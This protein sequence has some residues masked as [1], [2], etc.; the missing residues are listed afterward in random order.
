M[1]EAFNKRKVFITVTILV[2][3]AMIVGMAF[4]TKATT[5]NPY[6]LEIM[7]EGENAKVTNSQIELGQKIIADESDDTK[8]VYEL[9][10]KN[11]LE[12]KANIEIAV[13]IDS[14]YSMRENVS[15]EE[16]TTKIGDLTT[17]ILTQVVNARISVSDNSGIKLALS[18]NANN[19]KSA[20]SSVV[21][22]K[23][24]KLETGVQYANS[25]FSTA[26]N[27]RKIYDSNNRCYR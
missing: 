5:A 23:G 4:F 10:M 27:T 22:G 16:L 6:V 9:N 25:S 14:S 7:D 18:N 20:I 1:K 15:K 8:L 21:W 24:S 19:I 26:A 2:M 3:V 17:D 13:V 11:V 12:R